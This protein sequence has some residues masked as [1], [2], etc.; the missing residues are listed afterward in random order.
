VDKNAWLALKA[1]SP[2]GR[3]IVG[4]YLVYAS[5][6]KSDTRESLFKWYDTA[7]GQEVASF[8]AQKDDGF[9]RACFSPDG[10]TIA[11][12]SGL[13]AGQ[14]TI[15]SLFGATTRKLAKTVPLDTRTKGERLFFL[16][17]VFSPD[18]KW[19]AVI[20]QVL[21]DTRGVDLD[22]ADI[23]Q[24]RIHLIDVATGEIRETLIAPQ[25]IPGSACFSPDGRTLATSGQGR[26]LLWDLA[27]PP[28]TLVGARDI[29]SIE[30]IR[31]ACF[32]LRDRHPAVRI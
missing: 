18:S 3:L 25:G 23:A 31:A 21:P 32:A 17:P 5:P 14:K 26:V 20:T 24:A 27:R 11:A 29:R 22:P 1:M 10:K 15:L 7:N 2:D 13:S 28:G 4:N 9:Y 16:D 12:I 6:K 8:V 30:P 19:L